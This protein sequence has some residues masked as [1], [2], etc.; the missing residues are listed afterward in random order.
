[1]A[2]PVAQGERLEEQHLLL[3]PPI[4]A[5]HGVWTCSGRDAEGF[6][7]PGILFLDSADT[8]FSPTDR[9]RS[10]GEFAEPPPALQMLTPHGFCLR[11][12]FPTSALGHSGPDHSLWLEGRPVPCSQ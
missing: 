2:C 1:M 9:P 5:T 7:A 6:A 4:P 12:G 10:P 8:N 3:S 11:P